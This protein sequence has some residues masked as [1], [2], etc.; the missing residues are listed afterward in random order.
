MLRVIK[1]LFTA[2]LLLIVL[3]PGDAARAQ[4]TACGTG[5]ASIDGCGG[6]GGCGRASAFGR[7]GGWFHYE[8]FVTW[9]APYPYWWPNYFGPPRSDYLTIHYM[10]PPAET[11]LIVK[12]RIA[13][14]NAASGVLLPPATQPLM[15]PK[16]PLPFPKE[17]KQP[18][19]DKQPPA[20][21]L[22]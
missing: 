15:L 8:P 16:E 1:P 5:C 6:C 12:E 13:A 22:P 2:G 21:K 20:D 10:T 17:K 11:A 7:L 14:I 4:G 18:A 9:Y 3:A 19:P